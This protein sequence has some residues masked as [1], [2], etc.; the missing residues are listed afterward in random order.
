MKILLIVFAFTLDP[1]GNPNWSAVETQTFATMEE[2]NYAGRNL[3]SFVDLP[4]EIKTLS[5]CVS[6]KDYEPR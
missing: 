1:Y 6:E 4:N 3:R 5:Y 2:C